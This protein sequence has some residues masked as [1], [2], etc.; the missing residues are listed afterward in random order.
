MVVL[1][2]TKN[3]KETRIKD[4]FSDARSKF[5]NWSGLVLDSLIVIL[6]F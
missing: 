1:G 2:I 4:L 3:V 6:C 5:R